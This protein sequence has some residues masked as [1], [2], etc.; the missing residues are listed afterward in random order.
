MNK[1]LINKIL[2]NLRRII[3]KRLRIKL[4]QVDDAIDDLSIDDVKKVLE[5][6]YV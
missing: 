2:D 3:A 1:E 4:S 6:F 5:E